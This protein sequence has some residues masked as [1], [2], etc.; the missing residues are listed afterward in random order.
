MTTAFDSSHK[1][2]F[3][4]GDDTEKV[5]PTLTETEDKEEEQEYQRQGHGQLKLDGE[6]LPLI[7]Q[8]TD[9]MG[10]VSTVHSLCFR[11]ACLSLRTGIRALGIRDKL[12]R[13]I[14][15]ARGFVM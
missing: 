2:G 5:T 6:G 8:P 9:S 1:P 14:A 7:P 4:Y 10:D 11:H 3:E 13:F 12:Y 15:R